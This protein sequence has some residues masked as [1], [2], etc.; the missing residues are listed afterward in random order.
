M[1]MKKI[2]AILAVA[3]SVTTILSCDKFEDGRPAK[4]VRQ[5]FNRMYPD[6]WDV[7]WEYD[8]VYWEVN[9][10]TGSRPHGIDHEAWYDKDGTWIQTKTEISYN[11]VP[12]AIKDYLTASEYGK[13]SLADQSVDFVET[14]GENYYVFEVYHEGREV[15]VTVTENGKVYLGG[16][17]Y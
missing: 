2:F 4:D 17:Y 7:E 1:I 14:T 15:S 8:G 9:F 12:Q 3:V 6:A 11:A 16:L 5:E 13:G 10:E